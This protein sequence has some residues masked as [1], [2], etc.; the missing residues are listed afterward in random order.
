MV[1]P[2]PAP[3]SRRL[4]AAARESALT[5]GAV[6]GVLCVLV[7]LAALIARRGTWR[8]GPP[9]SVGHRPDGPR[10]EVAVQEHGQHGAAGRDL[11]KHMISFRQR[12]DPEDARHRAGAIRMERDVLNGKGVELTSS[13]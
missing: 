5:L 7:V 2:A 1:L 10:P 12:Y 8:D 3:P 9:A 13:R 4:T 6:T 11:G